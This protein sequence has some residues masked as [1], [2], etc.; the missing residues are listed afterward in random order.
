M[1][2]L[3]LFLIPA[4]AFLVLSACT[5]PN[6]PA[7]SEASVPAKT[8]QTDPKA[9]T[10][11]EELG[12]L[13]NFDLD[14]EDLVWRKDESKK[15][16]TAVVRLNTEDAKKLSDRLTTMA[17]GSPY[18]VQVDDWFPAELKAQSEGTSGS[19]VDGLAFPADNFYLD[20]YT[21]GIVVRVNDSDFFVIELAARQQ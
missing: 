18:S 8:A 2:F 12:M 17:P 9:S 5:N 11:D 13:I 19:T 3:R 16:L 4:I 21:K 10:S 15:T 7:N 1:A 6:G 14:P 20:P